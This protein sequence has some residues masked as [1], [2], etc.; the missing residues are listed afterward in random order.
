MTPVY[1]PAV[2]AAMDSEGTA[3]CGSS[4]SCAAAAVL[5]A[6]AA[7]TAADAAA[8]AVCGSSFSCAAAAVSEE[9]AA[10]NGN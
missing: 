10:A 9:T 6:A 3:A 8:T 7:T 2:D 1:V 5:G 4:F